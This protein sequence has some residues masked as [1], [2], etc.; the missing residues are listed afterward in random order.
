MTALLWQPRISLIGGTWWLHLTVISKVSSGSVERDLYTFLLVH[1]VLSSTS[2]RDRL[3]FGFLSSQLSR[4]CGW[5]SFCIFLFLCCSSSSVL[6]ALA[7]ILL[8]S[9]A[10]PVVNDPY[11]EPIC[12][13][14]H[15]RSFPFCFLFSPSFSLT[16]WQ[17]EIFSPAGYESTFILRKKQAHWEH[18]QL[19][20]PLL[21]GI[22]HGCTLTQTDGDTRTHTAREKWDCDGA[23]N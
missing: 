2:S 4:A 6:T 18:K 16:W 11:R 13:C 10:S 1:F 7:A 23:M 8:F 12:H 9:P 3:L 19:Y 20:A 21:G 14:S 17:Y 15:H 22:S 5:C